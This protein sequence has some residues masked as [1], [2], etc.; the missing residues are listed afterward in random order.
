MAWVK[1]LGVTHNRVEYVYKEIINPSS[2]YNLYRQQNVTLL[3]MKLG[4]ILCN[5]WN[6]NNI[7]AE[8]AALI[9]PL[10][11]FKWLTLSGISSIPHIKLDLN[12][13]GKT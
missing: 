2:H 8:I 6:S 13:T 4:N 12:P 3:H 7:K 1:V 10:Q 9:R 5:V 11:I